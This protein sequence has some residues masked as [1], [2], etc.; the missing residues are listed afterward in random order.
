MIPDTC[1]DISCHTSAIIISEN[2]LVRITNIDRCVLPELK[3]LWALGIETTCSCCGHGDNE[4]AYI[5]VKNEYMTKMLD[6]GYEPYEMHACEFHKNTTAFR[7]K[8]IDEERQKPSP[9]CDPEAVREMWRE[10]AESKEREI[11]V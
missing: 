1:E 10:A 2:Q 9:P 7:A 5:R 11:H 3:E 8:H 6:L 4:K